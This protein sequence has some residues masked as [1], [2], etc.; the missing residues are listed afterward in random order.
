VAVWPVAWRSPLGLLAVGLIAAAGCGSDDDSK[1]SA[2]APAKAPERA[3]PKELLGSYTTTLKRSDLPPNP[4][5][6]LTAGSTKWKLTIA[7]SGGV[8]NG[9]AFTIA[10]ADLGVL[11]SSSFGVRGDRVLLHKEECAAGGNERFYENQYSYGLPANTLTFTTVKNSCPDDVAQ[12]ILT[13]EPW[14]KAD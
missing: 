7:N 8:G 1:T 10:N 2:K 13:S 3:A 4:A 11:E 9:P 5:Q 12:T 14:T 6:E